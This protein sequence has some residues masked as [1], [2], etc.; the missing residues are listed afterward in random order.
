MAQR[1]MDRTRLGIRQDRINNDDI[2]GKTK[3]ADA[4]NRILGLKHSWAGHIMRADHD[5]RQ[6]RHLEKIKDDGRRWET[7][8][9]MG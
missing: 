9:E 1:T 7:S 5:A 4:V 2:R 6:I 3:V 8:H